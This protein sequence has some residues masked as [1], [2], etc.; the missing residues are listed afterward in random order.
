TDSII[1]SLPNISD[2]IINVVAE[3]GNSGNALPFYQLEKLFT[4]YS[5]DSV[6]VLI[7]VESSKWIETGLL[8]KG[9]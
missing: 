7:A 5:R 8:L 4:E 3:V 6:A 1:E 9:V 2:K